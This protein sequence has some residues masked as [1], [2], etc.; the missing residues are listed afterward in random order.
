MTHIA[1]FLLAAFNIGQG[2][3]RLTARL[4]GLK[5]SGDVVRGLTLQMEAKFFLQLPFYL[6]PAEKGTQPK[7]D[8]VPPLLQAHD[9]LGYRD[10]NTSALLVKHFNARLRLYETLATGLHALLN[11]AHGRQL[12]P[13]AGHRRSA[14]H[15]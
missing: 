11:T 3:V 13:A 2:A 14:L 10:H 6:I 7:G 4:A 15:F 1:A 12:S 8:H 9:V 5:T